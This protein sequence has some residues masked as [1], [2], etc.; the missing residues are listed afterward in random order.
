[1]RGERRPQ[2]EKKKEG[3]PTNIRL[4]KG[5][6]HP[7]LLASPSITM[8]GS[9]LGFTPDVVD[10]LGTLS[11]SSRTTRAVIGGLQ[12]RELHPEDVSPPPFC[13]WWE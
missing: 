8:R 1:M 10:W 12:S 3:G 2:E 5:Y 6:V 9:V 13:A 4:L 11:Q 7:R